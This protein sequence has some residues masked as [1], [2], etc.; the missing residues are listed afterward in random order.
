MGGLDIDERARAADDPGVLGVF[1]SPVVG[2]P[3]DAETIGVH[4]AKCA[5]LHH[6]GDGAADLEDFHAG[7]EAALFF[8]HGVAIG[9]NRD[10]IEDNAVGNGAEQLD[11]LCVGPDEGLRGAGGA[12]EVHAFGGHIG[13]VPDLLGQH[14]A[15]GAEAFES[16]D[17]RRDVVARGELVVSTLTGK[18]RPCAALAVAAVRAAIFALTVAIMVVAAEAD[19][20]WG[21]DFENVSTTLSESM[22]SGSSARRTP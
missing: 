17:V 19:A 14:A 13:V 12:A 8:G 16:C 22:I 5:A 3:C 15:E 11:V 18:D 10:T 9:D 21:F 7:L 4:D 1:G 2:G 6:R 20:V